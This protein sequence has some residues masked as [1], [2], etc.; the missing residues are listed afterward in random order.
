MQAII[1]FVP[2]SEI[3]QGEIFDFEKK[4]NLVYRFSIGHLVK[5]IVRKQ[6]ECLCL[7]L[8]KYNARPTE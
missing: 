1:F 8:S 5:N 7:S 6:K 4:I 2:A 3:S